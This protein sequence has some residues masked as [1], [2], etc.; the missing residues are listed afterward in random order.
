MVSAGFCHVL[1]QLSI[2]ALIAAQSAH[3]VTSVVAPRR[4]Q[5]PEDQHAEDPARELEAV[6]PRRRDEGDG[7]EDDGEL[8]ISSWCGVKQS[9]FVRAQLTL[10]QFDNQQKV[11][12]ITQGDVP[13]LIPLG[14][15][16]AHV[17]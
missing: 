2:N 14:Y 12:F 9:R 5:R 17:G 15:G 3:Q 11:G 8:I 6:R 16:Q 4:D 10:V 1:C 13:V 7:R